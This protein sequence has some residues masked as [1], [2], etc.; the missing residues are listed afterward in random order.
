MFDYALRPHCEPSE[1]VGSNTKRSLGAFRGETERIRRQ[2][3]VS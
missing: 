2:I 3:V 1:G